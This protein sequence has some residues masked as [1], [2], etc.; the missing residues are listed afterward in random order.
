M[1]WK[2]PTRSGPAGN[3]Y[4]MSRPE[5]DKFLLRDSKLGDAS[6]VH[7]FT[8][9]GWSEVM[10]RVPKDMA[11]GTDSAPVGTVLTLSETVI[12]RTS[13][14]TFVWRTLLGNGDTEPLTFNLLEHDAFL[15][16]ED[17][18]TPEESGGCFE[19]EDEMRG[20]LCG[21]RTAI[22]ELDH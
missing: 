14:N 2:T 22:S 1:L 12:E 5:E 20:I 9:K 19:V 15:S 3:C 13:P 11:I 10:E 17:E 4:E 18:F 21:G 7:L 16:C 8:F 6:P